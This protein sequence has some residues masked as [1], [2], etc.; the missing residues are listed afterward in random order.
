MRARARRFRRIAGGLATGGLALLLAALFP[1]P[2]GGDWLVLR[3]GSRV[4]TRGGWEERGRRV[5]FTAADGTL[6]SLKSDQVDLAASRKATGE[7]AEPAPPPAPAPA[8]AAP[9]KAARRWTNADI[10]PGRGRA[11]AAAAETGGGSAAG[12]TEG[13]EGTGEERT[14]GPPEERP[15]SPVVVEGWERGESDDGVVLV[16]RLR[17]RSSSQVAAAVELLVVLFDREG[18]RLAESRA[19]VVP[20]T[21]TA[22]GEADFRAELPGVYDFG[23][24]R[25]DIESVNLSRAEGAPPRS[26]ERA[27]AEGTG[28]SS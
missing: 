13:E 22:G 16:G 27:G 11:P 4:E 9:R 8:A 25:F 24:V 21:L 14:D 26:L 19:E 7:A 12:D 2:A 20:S 1:P 3:D 17:N 23:A 18:R 15:P 5:I 6:A 28:G 10:P